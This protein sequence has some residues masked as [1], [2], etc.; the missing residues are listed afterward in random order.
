MTDDDKDAI[1]EEAGQ[2]CRHVMK[3]LAPKMKM[4]AC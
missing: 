4:L 2:V 3:F 1:K